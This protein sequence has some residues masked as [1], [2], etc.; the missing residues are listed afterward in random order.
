MNRYLEV[1]DFLHP[2]PTPPPVPEPLVD[3]RLSTPLADDA[4]AIS[5]KASVPT[6]VV[7]PAMHTSSSRADSDGSSALLEGRQ[8]RQ[9]NDVAIVFYGSQFAKNLRFVIVSV[10]CFGKLVCITPH[11]PVCGCAFALCL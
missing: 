5:V 2:P 1:D 9:Q 11:H 3:Y 10:R 7:A 8:R 4:D 6:T